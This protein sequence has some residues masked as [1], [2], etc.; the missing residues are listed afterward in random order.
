MKENTN[1]SALAGGKLWTG[2]FSR[3]L[4]DAANDFNSSIRIDG[5]MYREDITGSIAHAKMLAATQIIAAED[6]EAIVNGL[7]EILGELDD[8]SL[9]ID[10]SYEDIHSFV[11]AE[12]TKR[13]GDA[14]KRLHTARSRNDQV[15]LDFRM[16]LMKR[17]GEISDGAKKLIAVIAKKASQY[18]S[19]IMPGYTHLQRAQPVSFAHHLLAYAF[20]LERDIGRLQDAAKRMN[21]LPLGS[22][23]LAGTTYD[24]DRGFV[25]RELGFDKVCENSIDG[26]SDRDFALEAAAAL[27]I[28]ATHLSRFSEEI[29]LWCS[30]E[31]GFIELDDSFSTGS[32]IMPQKKILISPSWCAEKADGSMA[33]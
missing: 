17:L 3:R 33:I 13:L 22:C 1:P 2:R 12:L 7:T 21:V 19:A 24:T 9:E 8:G 4:N 18:T 26:V 32:S 16:Y 6:G 10:L 25:C 29:I 5:R 28:V 30:K 23:A 27:A 31:F 20:M 15:A 14:G 11:E